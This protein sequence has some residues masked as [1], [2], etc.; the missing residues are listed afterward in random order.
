MAKGKQKTWEKIWLLQHVEEPKHPWETINM[1]WVTGPVPGGKENSN[2]CS[3]ILDRY[4][5][6]VRCLL[7]HKEDTTM[8]TALLFLDNII[9]TCGVPEFITSDRDPKVISEF[10]TNLYDI[11]GRKIAF[12]TAYSAQADGL[13]ERMIRIM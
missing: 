11:L 13:A 2:S 12:F 6:R 10:W 7:C 9:A 1:D 8:Y 3:V 5:K 4:F